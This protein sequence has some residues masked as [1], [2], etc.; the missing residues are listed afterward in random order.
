MGVPVVKTQRSVYLPDEV[1]VAL[2]KAAIDRHIPVSSLIEEIVRGWL[3]MGELAS[4][5]REG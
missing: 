4:A 5:M 1:W 3:L 2:R